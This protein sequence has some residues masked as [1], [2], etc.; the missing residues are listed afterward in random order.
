MEQH[1]ITLAHRNYVEAFTR[2]HLPYSDFNFTSMHCWDTRGFL[3]VSE[4]HG[5]LVVKFMDYITQTPFY[6]FLGTTNVNETAGY[7]LDHSLR[8][9]LVPCLRLVP[10]CSVEDLDHL[11]F[12]VQEDRDH[13]DYV[14]DMHDVVRAMGKQFKHCRQWINSFER[15]YVV[16][17]PSKIELR[18]GSIES[19]VYHILVVNE[20]WKIN[21]INSKEG[22]HPDDMRN[23]LD[24]MQRIFVDKHETLVATCLLY[25]GH[26]IAYVINELIDHEYVISHFSKADLAFS[27]V[28]QYFMKRYSEDMIACSRKFLNWEQ[29]LGLPGLRASKLSYR[30]NHFL[31]KY[32]VTR[33]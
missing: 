21:K 18:S 15:K 10:E 32:S 31:K 23:E 22:I 26:P 16:N 11:K 5:N 28:N 29:D 14:Y 17:D 3:R 7:L 24:A 25:E 6:S 12:M 4:I 1:A 19:M 27:G 13:F 2:N 8:E 33:I 20:K 30:P 9:S